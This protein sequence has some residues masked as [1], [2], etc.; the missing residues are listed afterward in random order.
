M[1]FGYVVV[2]KKGAVG[3]ER[4]ERVRGGAGTGERAVNE[5]EEKQES[6]GVC[7]YLARASSFVTLMTKLAFEENQHVQAN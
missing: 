3:A 7:K 1:C 6:A 5:E 2:Y 4:Q